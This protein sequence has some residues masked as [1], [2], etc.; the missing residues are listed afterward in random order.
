M[1]FDYMHP[2]VNEAHT[3][4][5]KTRAREAHLAGLRER[6]GMLFR[7]GYD[8]KETTSRLRQNV[9]WDYDMWAD[10]LPDFYREIDALVADVF[11]RKPTF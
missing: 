9:Q 2:D 4:E 6:A 8:K 10:T 7:L 11:K 5:M 3:D 1:P